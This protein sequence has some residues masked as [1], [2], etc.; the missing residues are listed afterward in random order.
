MIFTGT[1]LAFDGMVL[2]ICR[3]SIH[4]L[5]LASEIAGVPLF[6]GVW[7]VT[8]PVIITAVPLGTAVCG[9]ETV[10][11]LGPLPNAYTWPS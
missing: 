9:A 3:Y 4:A 10:V 8:V 2:V 1:P 11:A 7:S 5:M 6:A